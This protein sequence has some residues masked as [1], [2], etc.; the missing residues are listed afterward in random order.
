MA[1]NNARVFKKPSQ[2]PLPRSIRD[3]PV[4]E[5]TIWESYAVLP[6]KTRFAISIGLC[7][8]AAGGLLAS[9]YLEKN[10]SPPRYQPEASPAEKA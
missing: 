8:F 7:V 2:Q 10:M 4:A 3:K 1:K 6:H 9:Q 5:R